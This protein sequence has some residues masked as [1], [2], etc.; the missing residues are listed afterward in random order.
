MNKQRNGLYINSDKDSLPYTT[1]KFKLIDDIQSLTTRPIGLRP[2]V[3]T[4]IA[5]REYMK[6]MK[7]KVLYIA[8]DETDDLAHG[9]MYDQYLGSAYAEDRMLED[10]WNYI[11][12]TPQYKNK[13][14]LIVTCDHGRGDNPK[15]NW[16]HHG[17]KI[18][19]AGQIWI[20][21]IGPD[22]KSIGEIKTSKVLYQQQLAATFAKLLGFTFTANHTVAAPIEDIYKSET[23]NATSSK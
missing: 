17:E 20:A 6:E 5:A 4:Y 11:Q 2:D 12:S 21:A 18:E 16:Q 22:T 19:D 3:L 10:L 14:T 7:S 1:D 8:F 23:M 13:T 15:E 9:G